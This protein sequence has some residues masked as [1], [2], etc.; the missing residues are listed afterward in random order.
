MVVVVAAFSSMIMQSLQELSPNRSHQDVAVIQHRVQNCLRFADLR[1][2]MIPELPAAV[3][4]N[5]L[6]ALDPEKDPQASVSIFQSKHTRKLG[7]HTQQLVSL[8]MESF[9]PN[10]DSS[11]N[12]SVVFGARGFH[13]TERS[14]LLHKTASPF[15]HSPQNLLPQ[16]SSPS[17][18]IA[19]L[20]KFSSDDE[21]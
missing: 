18:W 5:A 19:A 2:G 21:S 13:A 3:I 9:K 16:C 12:P 11:R 1:K 7:K 20:N 14:P 6:N 17:D 8:A 15:R 10:T 4:S